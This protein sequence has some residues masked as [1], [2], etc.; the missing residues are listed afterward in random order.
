MKMAFFFYVVIPNLKTPFNLSFL[1]WKMNYEYALSAKCLVH[2]KHSM[3]VVRPSTGIGLLITSN[4]LGTSHYVTH[5]G[6]L[7]S[8][9]FFLRARTPAFIY[10][11]TLTVPSKEFHKRSLW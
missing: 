5:V 11:I 4:V 8:F 3:N 2:R 1:I 9:R 6:F 10:L 7:Y